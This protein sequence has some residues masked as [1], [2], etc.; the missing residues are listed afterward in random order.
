MAQ[1]MSQILPRFAVRRA[2]AG[3]TAAAL[4]NLRLKVLYTTMFALSL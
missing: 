4:L 3:D 2:F 1:V